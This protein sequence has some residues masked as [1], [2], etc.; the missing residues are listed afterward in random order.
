MGFHPTHTSHRTIR[1]RTHGELKQLQPNHHYVNL[2][3]EVNTLLL[4]M[5]LLIVIDLSVSL[6]VSIELKL[7]KSWI[8]TY[9]GSVASWSDRVH[10][11]VDVLTGICGVCKRTESSPSLPLEYDPNIFC[12]WRTRPSIFRC[13]TTHKINTM[14]FIT[15]INLFP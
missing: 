1:T 6:T 10:H 4:F 8:I 2:L 14:R 9:I 5:W 7:N 11:R 15:V 12:I 3:Y 13:P